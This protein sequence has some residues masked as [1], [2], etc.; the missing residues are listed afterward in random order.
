MDMYAKEQELRT[1]FTTEPEPEAVQDEDRAAKYRRRSRFA[2]WGVRLTVFALV[3]MMSTVL[4]SDPTIRAYIDDGVA[5]WKDEANARLPFLSSADA[6]QDSPENSGPSVREAA[7]TTAG[8]PA[9]PPVSI[10][11]NSAVPVRRAGS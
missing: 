9:R 3:S 6:P 8:Q 11:P 4:M 7:P 1:V 10:L 5:V 2:R